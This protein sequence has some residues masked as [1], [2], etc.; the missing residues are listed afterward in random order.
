MP[1]CLSCLA[2]R[3]EIIEVWK[4]NS[5]NNEPMYMIGEAYYY[6]CKKTYNGIHKFKKPCDY[7]LP[8]SEKLTKY[9]EGIDMVN[10]SEI[11]TEKDRVDLAK[12]PQ[13]ALLVAIKEEMV[14][15]QKGKTGGL[16]ITFVM[17]SDNEFTDME[18][19]QKY[20]AMSGKVLYGAMGNLGLNDTMELQQNMIKYKLTAMRTGFP[21]YIP[22]EVVS[23]ATKDDIPATPIKK[24]K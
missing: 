10:I 22:Y 5:F 17:K 9:I 1:N 18:F 11:P 2:L 24:R 14:E 7:Y 13:D 15:A 23:P 4:Y 19:P 21:R 12:L 3:C 8:V 16:V 6:W 20:S